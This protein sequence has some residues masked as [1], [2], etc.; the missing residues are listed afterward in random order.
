MKEPFEVSVGTNH[1]RSWL[2]RCLF[3]V[4]LE[5]S[6]DFLLPAHVKLLSKI[7]PL[8]AT[9]MTHKTPVLGT[10]TKLADVAEILLEEFLVSSTDDPDRVSG[11]RSESFE[12]ADNSVGGEGCFRVF[13]DWSQSAIV[14]EHE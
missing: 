12:G 11:I 14:V 6:H 2:T 1:V 8:G 9:R 13:D 10:E 5:A 3:S 4:F 7:V